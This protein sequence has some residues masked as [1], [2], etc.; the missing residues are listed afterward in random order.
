MATVTSTTHTQTQA[1]TPTGRAILIAYDLGLRAAAGAF[2]GYAWSIINPIG[3]A[4]FGLASAL[5]NTAGDAI[6]ASTVPMNETAAKTAMRVATFLLSVAAGIIATAAAGYTIT[7]GAAVGLSL[8]MI[9]ALFVVYVS[10]S[11]IASCAP[12]TGVRV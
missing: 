7:V 6:T 3:G 5:T 10:A 8:A 2:A 1:Q 4:I 9:P 12:N 11:C